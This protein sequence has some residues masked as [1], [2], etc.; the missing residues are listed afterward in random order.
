MFKAIGCACLGLC[1]LVCDVA[2][3]SNE[4]RI[5]SVTSDQAARFSRADTVGVAILVG[6]GNYPLYSGLSHL[7]YPAVDVDTLAATLKSQRY[8]VLSLKDSDATREAVLNAISQAAEALVGEN[9][10]VIFFFSGHGFAINGENYLATLDAG[11]KNLASSGLSVTAVEEALAKT[12][13]TRRVLWLDACRDEPGKGVGEARSFANLQA[14]AG[15]RLLLSTKA[16]KVSYEDEQLRQGLFSYYLAKGLQGEAAGPDGFVTF[17]D[18]ATYVTLRVRS[19]SLETGHVQVPYEAGEASGDFLLARANAAVIPPAPPPV[20]AVIE[21]NTREPGAVKTNLKDGQRYVR[22]PPGSFIM[23]CP[24]GDVECENGEKPVHAVSITKEFWLG[25]TAVTV[26]AWR[27]YSQVTGKPM[28]AEP[29]F[30]DRALN[31]GWE[32]EQQPIT[33]VS[34]EDAKGYCEWAGGQATNR[35]RMG[36]C[37]S[38]GNIR[39]PLRDVGRDCVVCGQ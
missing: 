24:T 1:V 3:Q 18:L 33:M 36:I 7:H 17:Q 11:V 14:A 10:T 31:Q 27:R 39:H 6:V 8:I 22:I 19:R 20:A 13:A 25:Q 28:P 38:C 15:T 37:G 9:Q 16:G 35:S 21:K 26:G 29:K 32:D 34:W 12:Q 23:G 2:A 4:K 30:L 5:I